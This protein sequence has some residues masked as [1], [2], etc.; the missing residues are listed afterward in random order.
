MYKSLEPYKLDMCFPSKSLI[1]SGSLGGMEIA[2]HALPARFAASESSSGCSKGEVPPKTKVLKKPASKRKATQESPESDADHRPLGGTDPSD[3]DD[4]EADGASGGLG[5]T[6]DD[7]VPK[8]L[9]VAKKPA[10]AA[11]KRPAAKQS[12]RKKEPN[13]SIKTY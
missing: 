8:D 7:G 1:R 4:E 9:K 6:D 2:H 10:T 12:R 5:D 3:D 13:K 11:K